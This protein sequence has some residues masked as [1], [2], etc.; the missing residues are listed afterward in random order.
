ME[1][2]IA[3]A[4]SRMSTSIRGIRLYMLPQFDPDAPTV[5]EPRIGWDFADALYRVGE[6]ETARIFAQR[7]L[8]AMVAEAGEDESAFHKVVRALPSNIWS[9]AM[10]PS[11]FWRRPTGWDI[12]YGKWMASPPI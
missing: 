2:A 11:I 4:S 3:A 9:A 5:M 1:K 8:D 10:R 6:I 7:A 12:A